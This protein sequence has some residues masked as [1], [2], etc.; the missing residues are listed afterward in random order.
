MLLGLGIGVGENLVEGICLDLVLGVD[1][2]M[3]VNIISSCCL[4]VFS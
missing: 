2:G 3:G 1:I 4:H